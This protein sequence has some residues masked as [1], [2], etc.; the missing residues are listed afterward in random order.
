MDDRAKV[1]ISVLRLF[2]EPETEALDLH[3]FFELTG[4]DDPERRTAVLEVVEALTGGGYL[5]SRGSDFYTLTQKGLE[6]VRRGEIGIG[7]YD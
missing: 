6:A 7:S 4:N 2:R 3:S 1:A 5:E